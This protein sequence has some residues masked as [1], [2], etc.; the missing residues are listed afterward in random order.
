MDPVT[1]LAVAGSTL[2]FTETGFKIARLLCRN[3]N[4]V[5]KSSEQA[6]KL[7]EEVTTMIGIVASL[8]VTLETY[9]SSIPASQEKAL[10]MTINS[11]VKIMEELLV[12]VEGRSDSTQ[13]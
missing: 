6:E 5:N 7:H 12:K 11:S 13:A 10:K 2:K 8:K 4:D 1:A 3:F 9:P